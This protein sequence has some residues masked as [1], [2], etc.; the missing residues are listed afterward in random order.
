M[1]NSLSRNPVLL[2]HG[3]DD[4]A[5]I[6]G[7]MTPYLRQQGWSVHSLNLQP[8]NGDVGLDQL[9]HQI[10]KY[11][12]K[13][14]S[15]DQPFDLVG[16]SMGGIVSRYYMQ[17]LGGLE[18]VQ[19]FVTIASPHYGTWTAYFR[20]NPGGNQ[21]RRGSAFLNRLNHDA[22]MLERINFTSIWTP[23][24]LMILPAA[25]SR[26][27]IGKDLQVPVS[28][29]AWM[30]TDVRSLRAVAGALSEPL[31]YRKPKMSKISNPPQA[32]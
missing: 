5:D 18:R 24:D 13:M 32:C 4:T 16:F 10:R 23:L 14:F 20:P 28:G 6:F 27:P 31:K 29:H 3:I 15:P 1:S 19:R 26:M 12:D 7:T 25:S 21:M 11:A 9:A 17:R 2:I 30:V 8:N 22:A